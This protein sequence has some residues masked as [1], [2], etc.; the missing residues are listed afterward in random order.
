MIFPKNNFLIIFI[1]L[2]LI[3]FQIAYHI[4]SEQKYKNIYQDM[5]VNE[6]KIYFE[7]IMLKKA[8]GFDI[9]KTIEDRPSKVNFELLTDD[10]KM[11]DK[12]KQSQTKTYYNFD[13]EQEYFYYY[14]LLNVQKN[15]IECHN[16]YNVGDVAGVVKLSI[17]TNEYMKLYEDIH[18]SKY[19]YMLFNILFLILII[20]LILF[21]N[22]R[23]KK[24]HLELLRSR[25]NLEKAE[26]MAGLGHWR[27]DNRTL[28][29]S[30]SK[31][32]L[33]LMG[34]ENDT[35]IDLKTVLN[36]V[37]YPKDRFK[38]IKAFKQSLQAKNDIKIEFRII[39]QSNYEKRDV[40]CQI[41]HIKDNITKDVIVSIGTVQDISRFISLSDKLL[42]LEEAVN[43]API[44]IV[45]TDENAN[46]EYVNPTFTNVTGYTLLEVLGKNPKILK[47]EHTNKLDYANLWQTITQGK[48]WTGTFKNIKKNGEEFW[49]M[50]LISPIFSSKTD[51][52]IKYIA[53]KEEITSK[54]YM[55]Q[56]LKYQE[57]LMIV[58]SRHAA[59]GEM[60][61]MIA[62]QWRQPAT[63]I[64][65][66]ANNIL[67]DVILEDTNPASL[68]RNTQD[69]I[70]QTKYLSQTIDD[71]RNF[72]KPNKEISEVTIQ[73]V[74]EDVKNMMKATLTSHKIK[75]IENYSSNKKIKTYKKELVQVLINF[76][77]NSQ[78]I[79]EEKKSNN[80]I[81]IINEY[82]KNNN[83]IL[84]VCDNAGGI[85]QEHIR[86]IFEP[87]FTTKDSKNGT[88]LGLYISK[89]IVEQH[90]NGTIRAFNKD[91]GAC[92]E[93]TLNI[94]EA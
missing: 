27:I 51:K 47:S 10:S 24:K 40:N 20:G 3:I 83:V 22:D 54:L 88:G 65:L 89:V 50:A 62:H 6:A 52:I 72:F 42:I 23:S 55:Q 67:T 53:I 71:F 61:S 81:I 76:V 15:C 56:K 32:M 9:T 92:L 13:K 29:I 11:I 33:Q 31:N 35:K 48:N 26:K 7:N 2:F 34:F 21:F 79:L 87:Y 46:I 68:K 25:R 90:L 4:N 43:Q 64:A 91:D 93:I 8:Q 1:F 44:S 36:K 82:I 78:E 38:L 70:E 39:N 28:E 18:D 77:K 30:F 74:I 16:K 5:L 66:C 37:V 75:L 80:K 17:N 41:T 19:I 86:K 60:I 57:E 84:Q 69:I 14:E 85:D 58:Q 59:M 63:V 45:I 94:K 73:E 12:V 49:E